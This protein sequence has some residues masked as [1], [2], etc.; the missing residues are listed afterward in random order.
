MFSVEKNLNLCDKV[1]HSHDRTSVS[2]YIIHISEIEAQ[3]CTSPF[4]AR[5]E[6]ST[7]A[8]ESLRRNKC[9]DCI[10]LITLS[11]LQRFITNEVFD[12]QGHPCCF[13]GSYDRS[14]KFRP[15]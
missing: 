5:P 12:L 3:V 9:E 14:V 15:H 7:R 11:V 8:T 1:F 4:S 13:D 2:I 6:N 10:E